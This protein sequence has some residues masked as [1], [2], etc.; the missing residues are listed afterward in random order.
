V[1]AALTGLLGLRQFCRDALCLRLTP[2]RRSLALQRIAEGNRFEFDAHGIFNRNDGPGFE[3]KGGK[4]RAELVNGG[5]IIAVQQHVT[6]PVAHPNNEQFD[7]EIVGRLPLRETSRMR[8][9]AFSYSIGDPCGRSVQVSMYF[10]RHN[11]SGMSALEDE[12]AVMPT[13]V[14]VVI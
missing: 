1:L 9:C 2:I 6:A 13:Y 7:L 10:I 11:A 4:H 12:A 5:R 3:D 14:G 8:F